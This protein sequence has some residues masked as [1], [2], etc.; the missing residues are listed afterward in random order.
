[1]SEQAIDGAAL[2]LLEPHDLASLGPSPH[3]IIN[4]ILFIIIIINYK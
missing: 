1:V 2:L 4:F 3:L